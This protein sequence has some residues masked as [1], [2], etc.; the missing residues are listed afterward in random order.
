VADFRD[1]WVENYAY[2]TAYRFPWVRAANE[3]MER[4]VL[5]AAGRV[6]V[7][8]PGQCAIQSAKARE[9]GKFETITNGY[10]FETIPRDLPSD[11]FRVSY[12]G[13]LSAQRVSVVLFDTL[14]SLLESDAGFAAD[15][16]FRFAGRITPAARGLIEDRLPANAVE[17]LPMLPH[18]EY[19]RR[20]VEHQLLLVLV[21]QVPHNELIIPAKCFEMLTTGNPL[22]AVGPP[23]GDTARLLQHHHGGMAVDYADAAAM[24]SALR[25][26]YAQWKAGRLNQ[27]ARAIP[28]LHRKALTRAL[29]GTFDALLDPGDSV[30]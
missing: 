17:F 23:Q 15:F 10:D 20:V 8:T 19:W 24:A 3:R 29:A 5:N 1:P 26:A 9:P 16:Q 21:D 22:L 30:A 4:S 2:N 14:R 13:S 11:R 27:G 25:D 12:Y 7:A 28:E 18:H 6:V